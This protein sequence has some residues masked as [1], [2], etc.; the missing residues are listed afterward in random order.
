VLA[1][2]LSAHEPF[3]EYD[4]I[5]YRP[6][7][8]AT[9]D[10]Q[11]ISDW[12]L[13]KEVQPGVYTL[14]DF[15]FEKPKKPLEA[16]SKHVA[17][18]ASADYEIYDYPGEYR[19]F[20][21]G[22]TYARKRIEELHSRHEVGRGQ[23]TAAG[24]CT[25]STFTLKD[26]PRDDQNRKYL[27]TATSCRFEIGEGESDSDVGSDEFCTCS[28]TA[29][30]SDV[31]FRSARTT[32][33][34]SIQGAQTAIVV[35]P[36]GEEIFTDAQ[37]RV[38][39]QFHWD[40]YGKNDENSSCWVRVSQSNA[41]K[42]WGS[43]ITPRIG[44]EV[45]VEFLEGDPDRPIITGRVYNGDNKPPYADGQGVVSGLKSSTHKGQ[46]FNEISMDD[47]SAKE[48]I[49]IHGQYDMD[50]KVGHDFTETIKNDAT[51][52]ITE[53]KYSHDVAAGTADYHV[54]GAVTEKF[55]STQKTT[56]LDKV[57]IESTSS[58]VV[59]KAATKI[60]LETG[61]SK[62]TMEAGGDIKIEG[63]NVTIK[64]AAAVETAG[65]NNTVKGDA[66]VTIK[67]AMVMV[68]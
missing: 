12:V 27:V 31:P 53:G 29:I 23:A 41:G 20:G 7:A 40:R 32:S 50:T 2:S 63:I 21:D 35:G 13:T 47:T 60:T 48:K 10:H 4:E 68:N 37:A 16:T 56:V 24:I 19:E 57:T 15:D 55:D 49:T 62:I 34:P 6:D 67:G 33:K 28:F 65:A 9:K 58:E 64:G 25:G 51:I 42:G 38:K 22:E 44:Q 17:G 8:K 5:P 66:M 11:V 14:N 46:G 43:M 39:V 45:I 54:K 59:I 61:A 52:K 1:D 26:H 3:P 18:H 30:P 36:K